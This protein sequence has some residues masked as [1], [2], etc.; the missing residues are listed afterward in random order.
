MTGAYPPSF[1]LTI[2]VDDINGVPIASF[3]LPSVEGYA[4]LSERQDLFV[5]SSKT[6]LNALRLGIETPEH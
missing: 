5:A 4:P 6:P 3:W 2:K 1:A